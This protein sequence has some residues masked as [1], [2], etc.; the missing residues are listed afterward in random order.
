M[1]TELEGFF[2]CGPEPM[3]SKLLW[4]FLPCL[5]KKSTNASNRKG[6]G[7]SADCVH[8]CRQKG[9]YLDTRAS[10]LSFL[11]LQ[12]FQGSVW[13]WDS[14][15]VGLGLIHSGCTG[16]CP[17]WRRLDSAWVPL[18]KRRH[19]EERELPFRLRQWIREN[20]PWW[21]SC[22]IRQDEHD[23]SQPHTFD[24]RLRPDSRWS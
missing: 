23:C 7:S 19:R 11:S 20:P 18:W 15:T 1:Q 4:K 17:L 3:D 14:T 10:F 8:E 22:S 13:C 5:L 9:K 2:L 16:N 24:R 21:R 6:I 12:K